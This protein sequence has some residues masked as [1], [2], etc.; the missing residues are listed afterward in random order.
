MAQFVDQDWTT[1][2]DRA[3]WERS[4]SRCFISKVSK[5]FRTAS[6]SGWL[7]PRPVLTEEAFGSKVFE[8]G[9]EFA[10]SRGDGEITLDAPRCHS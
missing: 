5:R 6:F 1:I 4:T 10:I 7:L 8:P 2:I 3:H 9:L